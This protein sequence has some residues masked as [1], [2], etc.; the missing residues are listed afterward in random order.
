MS[1][2]SDQYAIENSLQSDE[3]K[4]LFE[5]KQYIYV[6]D[7]QNGSYSSPQVTFECTQLTN[8]D[9]YIDFLQ[10]FISVP[11]VLAVSGPTTNN[12]A[13]A[14]ALSLKNYYL[15]LIN[16]I[17]VQLSGND[18]VTLSNLSN[19]KINYDILTSWSNDTNKFCSRYSIF[20][21]IIRKYWKIT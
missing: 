15:Q 7:G 13:N 10:G 14:F 17:Q 2:T 12:K 20:S 8:S 18:V 21:I 11:L 16:S 6:P 3:N 9:R 19:M 5:N 4:Y 1:I